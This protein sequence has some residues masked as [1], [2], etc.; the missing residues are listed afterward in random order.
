M[1]NRLVPSKK[2]AEGQKRTI[3]N[4][5]AFGAMNFVTSGLIASDEEMAEILKDLTLL[6]NIRAGIK[7]AREGNYEI[8][9]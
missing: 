6:R 2:S 9:A 4:F 3:S 1:R 7:D 5:I 8:V